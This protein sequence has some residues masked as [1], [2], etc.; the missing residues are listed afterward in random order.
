MFGEREKKIDNY[1]ASEL[2]PESIVVDVGA[3]N[4]ERSLRIMN[5][6]NGN[7][8]NYYLIEACH[9][10]FEEIKK[11][12]KWFN[13]FNI[14]IGDKNGTENFYVVNHNGSD[15]TSQAN[16]LFKEFVESKEWASDYSSV[17]VIV[18]TLDRFIIDNNISKIDFLKMNCEGSEY[19]I[20]DSQSTDFL[21]KTKF[22]YLQMHGKID[23]F[24]SKEMIRKKTAINSLL[25]SKG[26]ELVMGDKPSKISKTQKHIVQLWEKK[27]QGI[28][29]ANYEDYEKHQKE[30]T[31]NP[32]KRKKWLTV[33]WDKK[34][35]DFEKCFC[36][37]K[38][39]L[40]GMKRGLC[41]GARTGQEVISLSKFVPD[42]IGID[43]V[44]HLPHVLKGDV[45]D[46]QFEDDSFDFIYSNIF[47]HVLYPDKFLFEIQRVLKKGGYALLHFCIFQHIDQYSVTYVIDVDYDVLPFLKNLKVIKNEMVEDEILC[48][49]WKLLLQKEETSVSHD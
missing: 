27:R 35:D 14:A 21:D 2:G 43:L 10:N 15:G 26:F 7:P 4:G 1:V 44:E 18:C 24:N 11:K 48:Y 8:S 28:N 49:D 37:Y 17:V 42:S 45:H 3:Y 23:L 19:K 13:I 33:E 16:S 20:F 30:K 41:L 38:D 5:A 22:L 39:I 34:I 46:L 9:V 29:Y 40:F 32:E 36:N 31:L 12:N 6:S 25:L 47:D